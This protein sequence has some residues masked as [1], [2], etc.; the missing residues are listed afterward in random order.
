MLLEII[1]LSSSDH[2]MI[3]YRCDS[4]KRQEDVKEYILQQSGGHTERY[5]QSL[6]A[7]KEKHSELYETKPIDS[8]HNLSYYSRSISI[9]SQSITKNYFKVA[10]TVEDE[11]K[12]LSPS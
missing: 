11:L 7:K 8:L 10:L 4:F 2:R 3:P 12:Q 1:P 6:G 9:T 5:T